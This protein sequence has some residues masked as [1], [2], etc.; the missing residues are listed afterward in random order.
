[1]P[2]SKVIEMPSPSTGVCA[3]IIGV[4]HYTSLAAYKLNDVSSATV[5]A[6]EFG[7]WVLEHL[8]YPNLEL[9]YVD[10]LISAA[11]DL[12]PDVRQD[13]LQRI[14]MHQPSWGYS[15]ATMQEIKSAIKAWAAA[16]N[17]SEN[18][19]GIFYFCGHGVELKR[20][21]ALLAG[22]FDSENQNFTDGSLDLL[23]FHQATASFKAKHKY[24]FVDSCRTT[25]WK[26]SNLSVI[27]PNPVLSPETLD[28]PGDAP[29]YL[30]TQGGESA[31]GL[32][33][34]PAQ[35]TEAILISLAGAGASQGVDKYQGDWVV[36]SSQLM[37]AIG[38][39]LKLKYDY[40]KGTKQ[41][42]DPAGPYPVFDTVFHLP[43]DQATIPFRI[44]WPEQYTQIRMVRVDSQDEFALATRTPPS[45]WIKY[46]LPLPRPISTLKVFAIGAGPPVLLNPPV[47][48]T[49][50]IV[51]Y[52]LGT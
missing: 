49:P 14:Q 15:T 23:L 46:A 39:V 52:D 34:K 22:D 9:K 30:A 13:Y 31:W 41:A 32:P 44:T 20:V 19:I 17:E 11:G 48:I 25:P 8:K 38:K 45:P 29:L 24:F 10:M 1:M 21:I 2:T 3:L 26:V 43:G 47:H 33:N 18:N 5:S 35:F 6:L 27:T 37:S 50:P 12:D 36:T 40:E 7:S 51:Y 42:P 28:H 16:C 4:G